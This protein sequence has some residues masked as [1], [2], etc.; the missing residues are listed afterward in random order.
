MNKLSLKPKAFPIKSLQ[1]I[2]NALLDILFP[3]RCLSCDKYSEWICEDC[4]NKIPLK[5]NQSCPVCKKKI[6][7]DGSICFECR[8]K[9][10]IDGVLVASFYRRNGEKTLL[11]KT[12]HNYKYGFIIELYQPLAQ[13]LIRA[14]LSSNLSLPD[15]IIPIPL[16]P[17]R[18]RWRG[19]NQSAKLSEFLSE[20]LS[21]GF[22]I[23][24]TS[25]LLLRKKYT[26]PQMSLKN[27]QQR[28]AN[29]RN[30][31]GINKQS[32]YFKEVRGKNILL[33]DDVITTGST[34]FE[35]AKI[36]KQK[37]DAKKVFGLVLARQ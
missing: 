31:F 23:E 13:I 33:V 9:N 21:P 7:P 18:L 25:D 1:F 4:L 14:F 30:V 6:T 29:M 8:Q 15:F 10:S 22:K 17:R 35:C 36:L 28:I 19:F 34:I 3:I 11:A 32:I 20:N 16:H 12:I 2:R 27:R 37:T 5:S 26:Q 24:T